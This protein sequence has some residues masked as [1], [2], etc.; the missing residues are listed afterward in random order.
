M[1][2]QRDSSIQGPTL[3]THILLCLYLSEFLVPGDE[4]LSVFL[5]SE[6]ILNFPE[7]LGVLN[8]SEVSDMEM[9][10]LG[11]GRKKKKKTCILDSLHW[12][13]CSLSSGHSDMLFSYRYTQRS[14]AR[15]FRALGVI[16]AY[17]IG[18]LQAQSEDHEDKQPADGNFQTVR[19]MV[20]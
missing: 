3:S 20:E 14:S 4:C 17:G 16:Q 18:A 2:F 7:V 10:F 13:K 15:L 8:P 12:V 19:I 5:A 11:G 6:R 1:I 9:R